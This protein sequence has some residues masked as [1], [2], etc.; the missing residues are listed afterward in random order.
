[1]KRIIIGFYAQLILISLFSVKGISQ[2]GSIK[3]VKLSKFELQSS[4]LITSPGEVLS[5]KDYKTDVYWFPVRVPS[6][7]LS[8]LVSNKVYPDPYSGQKVWS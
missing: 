3:Q 5:A 6:T 2:S 4:A 7:V 8:G 1:M